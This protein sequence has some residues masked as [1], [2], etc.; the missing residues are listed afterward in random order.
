M[1]QAM[2][3]LV[4][5]TGVVL[6]LGF[7]GIGLVAAQS[8]P[9]SGEPAYAQ[10]QEPVAITGTVV[11]VDT[12]SVRVRTEAGQEMTFT[13]DT[14]LSIPQGLKSGDRVTVNYITSSTGF[15]AQS[16]ALEAPATETGNAASKEGKTLPQTAS[17]LPMLAVLGTVLL[18][19]G[20]VLVFRSRRTA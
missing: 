11:S 16:L 6:V 7:G 20:A 8:D 12:S 14:G 13:F 4:A 10:G 5:V 1:R 15:T 3:L 9:P 19:A 17:P 2:K 18:G